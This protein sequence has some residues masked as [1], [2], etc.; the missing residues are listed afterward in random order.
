MNEMQKKM[1]VIESC[2]NIESI[3]EERFDTRVFTN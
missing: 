2:L 3:G 1:F